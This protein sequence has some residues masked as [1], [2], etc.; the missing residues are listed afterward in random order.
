[1]LIHQARMTV[2]L[3]HKSSTKNYNALK[4]LTFRWTIPSSRKEPL[5]SHECSSYTGLGIIYLDLGK[6]DLM[7]SK[8]YTF[9]SLVFSTCAKND[10]FIFLEHLTRVPT[11]TSSQLH[12]NPN[13]HL[14]CTLL[15]Y[16]TGFS[17]SVD[18]PLDGLPRLLKQS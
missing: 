8:D 11:Y 6:P 18:R 9:P 12:F 1:V 2:N 15:N 4:E 13:N 17:D 10:S 14:H 16:L 3:M 5:D 7:Y